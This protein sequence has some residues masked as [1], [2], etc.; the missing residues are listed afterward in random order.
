MTIHFPLG[1]R[2]GE[3]EWVGGE[4]SVEGADVMKGYGLYTVKSW[5]LQQ[6]SSGH[7]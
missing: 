6:C 3:R 1:W 4:V 2:E 5:R 7:E